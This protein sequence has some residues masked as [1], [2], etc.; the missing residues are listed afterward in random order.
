M[1]YTPLN[2][3]CFFKTCLSTVSMVAANPGL[4]ASTTKMGKPYN[5]VVLRRDNGEAVTTSTFRDT[6]SFIFH[7]PYIT[8]PCFLIDLGK[9]VLPSPEAVSGEQTWWPGGVGITRSIVAFSAICAHKLSYPTRST[10][11]IS[12]RSEEVTFVNSQNSTENRQQLIYCCSE[13]SAY[14]PVS[15]AR[16]VG[17]PAPVPLTAIILEYDHISDHFHATGTMGVEQ[18]DA[19]FEKFEYRIALENETKEIRDLATGSSTVFPALQYS[20]NNISC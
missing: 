3:R 13:R 15:G 19:F 16:V 20:S 5:R 14:D 4:L 1:K 2:R 7:Y 9:E 6:S 11:F 18:Y 17:G 10:S 12:Y 8:T